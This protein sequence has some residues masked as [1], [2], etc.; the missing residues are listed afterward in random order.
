MKNIL[1]LIGTALIS[2]SIAQ[3]AF[4][5]CAM[6]YQPRSCAN[7]FGDLA[8]QKN[9]SRDTRHRITSEMKKNGTHFRD[10]TN[11]VDAGGRAVVGCTKD[12]PDTNSYTFQVTGCEPLR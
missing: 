7:N 11:V 4:A 6:E 12:F 5:Q 1:L 3:T 8:Y 9:N 2:V 10:D